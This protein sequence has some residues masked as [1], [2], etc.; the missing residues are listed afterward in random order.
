MPIFNYSRFIISTE[1][2]QHYRPQS[3]CVARRCRCFANEIKRI[4]EE[5]L[6]GL[7]VWLEDIFAS[8]SRSTNLPFERV[9]NARQIRKRFS[10]SSALF[11]PRRPSALANADAISDFL[12]EFRSQTSTQTACM[13]EY[14][15]TGH[16]LVVHASLL[17]RKGAKF[18]QNSCLPNDF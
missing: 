3:R 18:D 6:K 8:F 10:P 13:F 15:F 2:K 14:V 4:I 11:S 12:S 17:F 16:N 9:K 5:C 7:R 1:E